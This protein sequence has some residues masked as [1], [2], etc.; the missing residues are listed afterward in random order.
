MFNN[1]RLFDNGEAV[2]IN[3]VEHSA[4]QAPAYNLHGQRVDASQ[5]GIVIS[6]DRKVLRP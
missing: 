6:G 5:R 4:K 1:I 3:C 2:G